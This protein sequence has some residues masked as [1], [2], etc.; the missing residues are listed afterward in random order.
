MR[1]FST[2]FTLLLLS[3]PAGTARAQQVPEQSGVD[4]LDVDVRWVTEKDS[5]AVV[6]AG[7][8][9]GVGIGTSAVIYVPFF[10][11]GTPHKNRVARGLVISSADSTCRVRLTAA[12]APVRPGYR[13]LLYGIIPP[14]VPQV[15]EL[16]PKPAQKKKPFYKQI[17]FWPV[18]GAALTTTVVVIA[19]GGG[20][21][22]S[23]RGTV[24]ISGS[25]P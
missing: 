24:S 13:A 6:G 3:L 15:A 4:S 8:I 5:L 18:V 22:K 25:L 20:G 1:I 7:T 11:R 9:D 23:N 2:C 19:S 16:G 10:Y 12:T 21:S 14:A 17:W